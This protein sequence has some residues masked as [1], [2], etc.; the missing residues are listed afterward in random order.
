MQDTTLVPSQGSVSNACL[1]VLCAGQVLTRAPPA[2]AP[3][4]GA[5]RRYHIHTFGCQMNL[6]DS[7]RMAGTL[8]S[9]GYSC[10][11]DISDADV[12]VYNTCSIRD[13]AE[14]KVYSALGKQVRA[15]HVWQQPQPLCTHEQ[16]QGSLRMAVHAPSLTSFLGVAAAP[17]SQP[18]TP[19]I[20]AFGCK[21]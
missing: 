10:A 17:Q 14:Q 1:P 7:E 20:L 4:A 15:L 8:E 16:Q 19:L 13:K 9:A 3:A 12:I 2:Q 21:P 6:A 5:G 11:D 18:I